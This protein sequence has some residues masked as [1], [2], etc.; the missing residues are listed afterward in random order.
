MRKMTLGL[1]A[2]AL[3]LVAGPAAADRA[4]IKDPFGFEE[5]YDA[6]TVAIPDGWTYQGSVQWA[7]NPRCALDRQ[8]VHLVTTDQESGERI[9]MIPGGVWVW[10][11]LY[12]AMPQLAQQADCKPLRILTAQA[13]MQQYLPAIRPGAEVM[14]LHP[15]PE[16]AQKAMAEIDPA[17]LGPGQRPRVEVVQADIQYTGEKGDVRE[18]LIGSVLFIDQPV[19]TAYPG[20]HWI[21]LALVPGIASISSVGRAPDVSRLE[22]VVESITML[23]AYEQRLTRYYQ[24]ASRMMAATHARK[25]AARQQWLN[26]RRAAAATSRSSSTGIASSGQDVLDIQ[27]DTWRK[28]NDM[29]DAGHARSVDGTLERTPWQ[30]TSGETVYMPQG[31]QRIY[32]LPND[33]YVGTNDPFFNPVQRTGQFGE[34]LSPY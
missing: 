15:R 14:G 5:P 8:K 18:V 26:A 12:D 27:M 31:Y 20:Q 28:T 21:T 10:G 13:F 2:C 32:Q 7:N 16:L 19:Q 4:V 30:N 3:G 17:Q 29:N 24:D 33:V 23:P 11:T 9:E 1:T 34:E 22:K 25:N 6:Y